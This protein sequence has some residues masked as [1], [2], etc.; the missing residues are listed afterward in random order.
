MPAG[1]AL[2]RPWP[3]GRRRARCPPTPA[4]PR[5]SCRSPA[6]RCL[7]AF[8]AHLILA[9][10]LTRRTFL[11]LVGASTGAAITG[12]EFLSQ[13]AANAAPALSPQGSNGIEH[14]VVLM[15]ENPSFDHFLTSLPPANGP[16]DITYL[17]T[18]R[19]V[20]PNY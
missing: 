4:G 9:F 19:T 20:S 11:Q 18:D 14:V 13:T 5:W 3:G 6:Y 8:E 2:Q 12:S 1:D 15:M 16:T 7:P 10:M 17:P